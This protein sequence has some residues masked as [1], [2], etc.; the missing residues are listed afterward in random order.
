M[1]SL[2]IDSLI[3]LFSN[4]QGIGPRSARRI[5]LQ[6]ISK[7][8]SLMKPLGNMMIDVSNRISNCKFCGN[9]DS[10]NPCTI[11]TDSKRDKNIICIVEEVSDLWALE[12][13]NFF[14]G[15]YH[16]LGGTLDALRG[17]SADKLNLNSFFDK[18]K[19]GNIKEVILATSLTTSGQTTA[20]YILNKLKKLDIKITRLARGLPAGGEL[21][22][23]DEATLGQAIFERTLVQEKQDN[24]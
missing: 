8:N 16:V 21:D 19:E 13:S 7:K 6:L 17:I 15:T 22:Y 9:Y 18:I 11:C 1:S 23:I 10:N 4:L 2:E 20:H 3:K 5:V 12:R 14:K 24:E